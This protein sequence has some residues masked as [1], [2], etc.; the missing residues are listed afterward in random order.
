MTH[1]HDTGKDN[2]LLELARRS[3]AHLNVFLNE[4]YKLYKLHQYLGKVLDKFT[5]E[6]V[7][8]RAPKLH[9]SLP[10]QFGKTTMARVAASRILGVKPTS[11]IIWVSYG[12]DLAVK[13]AMWVRKYVQSTEFDR[14]FG[15]ITNNKMLSRQDDWDT[16]YG[17]NF[18]AR[19]IGGGV[20]GKPCDIFVCDDLIKDYSDYLSPARREAREDWMDTVMAPRLQ[21]KSSVLSIGSRYGEGD[22]VD[23]LLNL[24][25]GNWTIVNLAA[26]C[27]D[28]EDD[29]L[30]RKLGESLEEDLHSRESL[31]HTMKAIGPIK[32]AAIYKG[33]P[34]FIKGSFFHVDDFKVITME[35]KEIDSLKWLRYWDLGFTQGGNLSAGALVAISSD[36]TKRYI[37]DIK[38]S[39]GEFPETKKLILSTAL[40]DGRSVTCAGEAT[41]TQVGYWQ[42]LRDIL[43]G[44]GIACMYRTSKPDKLVDAR[45]WQ[46]EQWAGNVY[47]VEGSWIDNFKTKCHNFTAA[48]KNN[49]DDEIDAVSGGFKLLTK[50]TVKQLR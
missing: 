20:S 22:S 28:E 29:P 49:D 50:N 26:L 24:I 12:L 18:L 16:H 14:A 30:G 46:S 11:R 38:T 5:Y 45:S 43:K 34:L 23:H 27:E 19:G 48:S 7:C 15:A 40:A 42:E 3:T 21:N 35:Q 25:H 36:G 39:Q 10:P 31:L 37:R 9:I 6:Y 47:L 8:G 13:S 17:G 32:A 41:G 2:I 1:F 33:V 44:H 4:S